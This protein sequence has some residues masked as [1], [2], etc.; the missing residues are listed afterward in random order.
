MINYMLLLIY[1]IYA[2]LYDPETLNDRLGSG[3]E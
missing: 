2:Q 3:N 1:I